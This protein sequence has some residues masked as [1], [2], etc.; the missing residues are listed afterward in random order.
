MPGRYCGTR[1]TTQNLQ[2]VQ[3]REKEHL[4]LIKGALPGARNSLLTI[5]KATKIDQD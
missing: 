4:I 2:V 1:V 3:V 5:K